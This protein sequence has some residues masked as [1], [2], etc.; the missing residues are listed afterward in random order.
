MERFS[1]FHKIC[2]QMSRR[3]ITSL[4]I[5]LIFQTDK[6]SLAKYWTLLSWLDPFITI[7]T[8]NINHKLLNLIT[9][10]LMSLVEKKRVKWILLYQII[11]RC[12]HLLQKNNTHKKQ[13]ITKKWVHLPPKCINMNC[14][15]CKII[16]IMY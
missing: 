3:L 5:F 16:I 14:A 13:W 2:T 11:N 8:E 12:H 1:E 15:K 4:M 7:K 6:R 9:K 10:T